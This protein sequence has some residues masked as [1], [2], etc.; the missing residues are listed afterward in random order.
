MTLNTHKPK[1][2][3]YTWFLIYCLRPIRRKFTFLVF[4]P[5][6]CLSGVGLRRCLQPLVLTALTCFSV[7]ATQTEQLL[8][9][10]PLKVSRLLSEL[11]YFWWE[12]SPQT[13]NFSFASRFHGNVWSAGTARKTSRLTSKTKS[14]YYRVVT[15]K[16]FPSCSWRRRAFDCRR[17]EM[18]QDVCHWTWPENLE[19]GFKPAHGNSWFFFYLC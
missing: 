8:K 18:K 10:F 11:L 14:V 16:T 13:F 12:T 19:L 1:I 9:R 4:C 3:V 2:K 15:N 5:Q 6:L 17:E 7:A